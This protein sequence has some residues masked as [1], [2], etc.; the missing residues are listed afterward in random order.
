MDAG[1]IKGRSSFA[2]YTEKIRFPVFSRSG[3]LKGMFQLKIY[4]RGLKDLNY[5]KC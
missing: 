5:R 1:P 4:L 3:Q 2:L